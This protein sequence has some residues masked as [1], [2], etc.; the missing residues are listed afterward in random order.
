MTNQI[1]LPTEV[2]LQQ[3]AITDALYFVRRGVL[4]VCATLPLGVFASPSYRLWGCAAVLCITIMFLLHFF[5]LF[6]TFYIFIKIFAFISLCLASAN[7]TIH[8]A[9][10]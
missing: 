3:G 8:T 6:I 2:V 9:N 7:T 1:Y 5:V 10:S 4:E